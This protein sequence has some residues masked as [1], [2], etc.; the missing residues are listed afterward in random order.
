M[1]P[2]KTRYHGRDRRERAEFS[3]IPRC[4]SPD[5]AYARLW[6]V[7]TNPA[8]LR[9][10]AK[11]FPALGGLG[12]ARVWA[13]FGEDGTIL[14]LWVECWGGIYRVHYY[15]KNVRNEYELIC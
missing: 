15:R 14:A 3:L 8:T 7:A 4:D 12:V 5:P 11:R 6:G 1:K 10:V 9:K 2:P 13:Q